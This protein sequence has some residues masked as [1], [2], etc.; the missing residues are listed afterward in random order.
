MFLKAASPNREGQRDVHICRHC[1]C[2][3][4]GQSIVL[5]GKFDPISVQPSTLLKGGLLDETDLSSLSYEA[6]FKEV[7]VLKLPWLILS[8]ELE[9]LSA[10]TTLQSPAG[11]PIR[12]FVV[13]FAELMPHKRF[14][15]LGINRDAHMPVKSSDQFHALLDRLSA[16][17]SYGLTEEEGKERPHDWPGGLIKPVLRS[18]SFEGQRADGTKGMLIVRIEPSTRVIPGLYVSI[19]DHFD[20]DAE[21]LDREP[22]QLLRQLTEGWTAAMQRADRIVEAVREEL[23]AVA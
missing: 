9:K 16:L 17:M 4:S 19:N 20:A 21:T 12:D 5:V 23:H 10:L 3:L 7:A 15:A 1:T 8:V 18:I 13:D 6:L 2:Q 22:E 14:T 11:E